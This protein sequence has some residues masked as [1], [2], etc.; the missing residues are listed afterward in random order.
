L[1]PDDP[2]A[3]EMCR[4]GDCNLSQTSLTSAAAL[5]A[6][7]E[8]PQTNAELYR[9]I[10]GQ[11]A[12]RCTQAEAQTE[13]DFSDE[14]GDSNDYGSDIPVDVI[15]SD[16]ISE[17]TIATP[18]FETDSAGVIVRNGAAEETEVAEDELKEDVCASGGVSPLGRGR[19][20][21]IGSTRYGAEWEGH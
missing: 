20:A 8:L 6:L 18:G 21:K 4:V 12:I 1:I 15:I 2:Q 11:T 3:F 9:E 17:G 10:T 13:A 7:R 14:E 16:I 5:T 19:R